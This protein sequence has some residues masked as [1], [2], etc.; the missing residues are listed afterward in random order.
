[1]KNI[2]IFCLLISLLSSNFSLSQELLTRHFP[3]NDIYQNISD[4]SELVDINQIKE[5]VLFYD[6]NTNFL[7]SILINNIESINCQFIFFDS[8]MLS[9]NMRVFN[10]Y[11]NGIDLKRQTKGGII[12]EKHYPAFKTYKI[13]NSTNHLSGVFIFSQ[14]G[15]KAVFSIYDKMYQLE[16]LGENNNNIYFICDIHNSPFEHDFSC[17]NDILNQDLNHVSN[18]N[19]RTANLFGCI[20][21]A[22][23]IDYYTFQT[24]ESYQEAVDW[25]L[26]ILSVANIVYEEEVDLRLV[27]SSAIVWELEDPYSSFVEDPQNMLMA[28]RDAWNNNEGLQ[29]MD[30]DLVH[31]FS[32]R[33]DTGTGGIAFL[34]GVGS[35]FNGYGFSSGLVDVDEYVELPAPYFFWNIY[36]LVHEL[37]HNFGAKHTQWCGWPGGPIDNCA[38][39]EEVLPG[40]CSDYTNNPSP[41]TGTIMSYCHTWSFQSGGGIIMKFNDY[42]KEALLA[43]LGL[44][45]LYDCEND[46]LIYGCLDLSAC[47]YNA[48]ATVSDGECIYPTSGYD[49]FGNCLND[50]NENGICDEEELL[51]MNE[52]KAVDN[53]FMFPNPAYQFVNIRQDNLDVE[54][55]TIKLFNSVG[56]LTLIKEGVE[57][58]SII[59]VSLISP[60]VY[61]AHLIT[62]SEIKQQT[63]IIQ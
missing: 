39:I 63:I 29:E 61:S 56:R 13:D 22:I 5:S 52:R 10:N 18:D 20:D 35:N 31:L 32:K 15:V 2:T 4:R 55:Y 17:A 24:F 1:M 19:H 34:N 25:A 30:R 36:C 51:L 57:N 59:D 47:N 37:G 6:L 21:I 58:N 3:D 16:L 49:C 12:N 44:Q 38:N 62:E 53:F 40:E 26:E 9:V 42:V 54:D 7:D 45:N 14:E 11:E 23:E 48:S 28:L 41:Q 46:D 33:N 8:A 50:Q 60:G 43:Y 27:S